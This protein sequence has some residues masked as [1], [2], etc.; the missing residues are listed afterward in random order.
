MLV[1][2][3]RWDR[4]ARALP[5]GARILQLAD[6]LQRVL[7]DARAMSDD[8]MRG[9]VQPLLLADVNE[10]DTPA[11]ALPTGTVTFLLSDVE[12]SSGLWERSRD[13][14]ASAIARQYA[15]LDEAIVG[16]GGV[17][18][19]EQGEGD[20]VVGAFSR[21]A[22]A[23]AAALRAQQMLVSEAWPD[24]A[25]LRVRMALHTGD[26][27]LRDAG[28]YFGETVIRCARLRALAHGGQ[29]ILS[30]ATGALAADRLPDGASLRDLGVHRLKDLARPERILQLCDPNLPD[31]FPPLRSLDAFRHNLPI[32]LTPFVGRR[33][34]VLEVT[35]LLRDERLVT[36]TGSGGIG[37]TRLA[38]EV[39]AGATDR[40]E[41][42]VWFIELA[43]LADGDSPAAAALAAL[44]VRP[45]AGASPTDQL[46]A[47]LGEAPCLL[48]L[49]N[50][51]HLTMS[52]AALIAAL[53][54]QNPAVIVLVTSREPLG[55][56]GEVVWRVPCLP[57]PVP[58]PSVAVDAVSQY[59]AVR[60][61]VDRAR[62]A[63]PSFVV[64]ED[65]AP[66]IAQI[67]HQLDG[68]PLALELAAARCR[69][70]SVERIAHD[71]DDSFRLL[72]GG[73]RTV[74]PRQQTLGASIDWSHDRLDAPE[75]IVFRRLGV[76][77]GPVPLEA[78]EAIVGSSGVEPD[79][80]FDIV[81]RL[82][83][84]SLV[85]VGESPDGEPRYR[86]LE[87]L[88]VYAARRAAEADELA[89]L[90][91]AHANWWL[92]W[93]DGRAADLH[94]D[95]V[96]ERVEEFHDN[97]KA[98]L[99]WGINEPEVGLHLLRRLARPWTNSARAVDVMPSVD[100]LLTDE[101][102]SL[103]PLAWARAANAV[104][105][106]IN[107]ARG[108]GMALPLLERSE[109][110][111]AEAGD[112]LHAAV[113]RW[114]RGYTPSRCIEVRDLAHSEGDR[115]LEGL[116]LMALAQVGIDEAPDAAITMLETPPCTTAARESSYL[117]DFSSRVRATAHLSSGDLRSAIAVAQE[118]TSSRSTLMVYGAVRILNAAALLACH[119]AALAVAIQ[120]A[121][122]R[123]R[124]IP[125][126]ADVADQARRWRTL[127]DG[128][129]TVLDPQLASRCDFTR[130]GIADVILREA[131]DAGGRAPVLDIVTSPR[132]STP[133]TTAVTA[134]IT[135]AANHDDEQWYEALRLADAHGLRLLAVDCFEGLA[136]QA[137]TTES[138]TECLRLDGAAE[139][140]RDET[141]Y[142]W[143]FPG[144]QDALAAARS[145]AIEAI[146]ADAAAAARAE[147]RD[148]D[149]HEA[150]AFARR[151]RG[152]RKRPRNGWE[153]L[154]PT[155]E[156]VVSLVV[157]GLTNPQIAERML[158]GRA[159]VK[160]HL[161]HIFAKLGVVSRVELAAQ[162]ARRGR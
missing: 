65:N 26:A 32:Q 1:G 36:L 59:D 161:D 56:P 44:R 97:L 62:R 79:E 151:A 109:P 111:A 132:A 157:E 99:A 63:R 23:V 19:V 35:R 18:P 126:T 158:I 66:A 102:A 9:R 119:E 61:F 37:K 112:Q 24:A 92:Q 95:P 80:V 128:A 22:D 21:A 142:R 134:A 129:P 42:G 162:A 33:Q 159:T 104:S 17:R 68:I 81:D 64:N 20:S 137:A 7:V 28:N 127:I 10:R 149:W 52:C 40:F 152:E 73:A 125:G 71:L 47:A 14:M 133:F 46:A 34:E 48:V 12:G 30:D 108:D 153:S 43:G 124:R 110:L 58:E 135:A 51:E 100:R 145:S 122:S 148:L 116:A 115:Y 45:L 120:V 89:A 96:V 74:L 123:L 72:T 150:V 41:G 8:E 143:R 75:Q 49:D 131:L 4:K 121:E 156:Q 87:T 140:L 105:V 60:L 39:A 154:T 29:V 103:H 91:R 146:G 55:V 70:L 118:L 16:H 31:M 50:C 130:A 78:V 5:T 136:I 90:E 6:V 107:T 139:R 15:I 101:N 85:Q 86:L 77:P 113:A 84:K 11:F 138:W 3:S 98:A 69:H 38:L 27:Q 2:D 57:A 53:L 83:D 76:F 106:L 25:R 94:S 155:E 144:E 13:A 82:C 141:G 54:V 117:R 67:C 88:R 147:G 93:L 114:L 160:T